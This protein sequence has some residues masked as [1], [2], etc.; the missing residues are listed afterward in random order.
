MLSERSRIAA[1]AAMSP[2]GSTTMSGTPALLALL[3]ERERV[4]GVVESH[5]TG[6][7]RSWVIRSWASG[8]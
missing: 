1:K 7:G 2:T 5:G 6:W 8:F 4:V 3:V